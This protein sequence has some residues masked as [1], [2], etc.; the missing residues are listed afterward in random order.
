[1][2]TKVVFGGFAALMIVDTIMGLFG[3]YHVA[4]QVIEHFGG[5]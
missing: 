2:M 1:M 3:S 5:R 4:N